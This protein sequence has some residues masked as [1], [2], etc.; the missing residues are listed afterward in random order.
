MQKPK[1]KFLTL[2]ETANYL[3]CSPSLLYKLVATRKIP[4]TRISSKILF[5]LT[6]VDRY[7]EENTVEVRRHTRRP[8]SW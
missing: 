7:I 2:K 3:H 5:E 6:N 1:L 4:H 8:R